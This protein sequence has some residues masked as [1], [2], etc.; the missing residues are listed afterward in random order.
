MTHLPKAI[1]FDLDDTILDFT[2]GA[3]PTWRRVC[4]TFAPRLNGPT[5]EDLYNAIDASR[6]WFWDDPD[7]HRLGRLDLSKA[8]RDIVQGALDRLGIDDP[9][10]SFEIAD[11]YTVEREDVQ[12][13]PG[14]LETLSELKA[15]GVQLALITNGSEQAQRKKIDQF[16]LAEYFDYILVEGEFGMG[17]PDERVYRH[18]MNELNVEPEDCWMVGDNLEWEVEVPQRLGIY[19]V[20]V[21]AV[22]GGLPIN[23]DVEPDRVVTKISEIL[24]DIDGTEDS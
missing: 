5:Q 9:G 11:T 15:R 19:A 20:W 16:G 8:R 6:N 2:Q 22:E 13:F 21:D 24:L 17:K 4:A 10:V 1:L 12:P 7:R 3:D 23:T 14:A 18:A